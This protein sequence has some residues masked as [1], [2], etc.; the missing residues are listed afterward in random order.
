[1][2]CTKNNQEVKYLLPCFSFVCAGVCAYSSR[3][4]FLHDPR[5]KIPDHR[6]RKIS[7]TI[8]MRHLRQHKLAFTQES[9]S[10]TDSTTTTNS[11]SS[12]E[13]SSPVARKMKDI[14]FSFPSL[15]VDADDF[16]NYKMYDMPLDITYC[17]EEFFMWYNLIA[18]VTDKP[19]M[20]PLKLVR[21]T[22]RLPVFQTLSRGRSLQSMPT[23]EKMFDQVFRLKV[24]WILQLN[25]TE[26]DKH[27]YFFT[28]GHW[29][30]DLVSNWSLA[31]LMQLGEQEN[32][33]DILLKRAFLFD[34]ECFSS[35][36]EFMDSYQVL[37]EEYNMY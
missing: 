6:Q 32:K 23:K 19:Y 33:S 2:V 35:W 20:V 31:Y 1:M 25:F 10:E 16:D 36:A 14:S 37:N 18:Y 7:E 12:K 17:K 28:D 30:W 21:C 27:L 34:K 9:L 26:E 8:M 22:K 3:C 15:E 29:N 5:I 13:F 4:I 11:D 24:V